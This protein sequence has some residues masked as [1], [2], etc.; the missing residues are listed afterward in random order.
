[1]RVQVSNI[2]K[3]RVQKFATSVYV[4]ALGFFAVRQ[5]VVKNE[6]TEPNLT[7]F[8]LTATDI[9]FHGEKSRALYILNGFCPLKQYIRQL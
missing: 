2:I 4:Q 1:M 9:F 7:L 8:D 5:F 6:K 3:P